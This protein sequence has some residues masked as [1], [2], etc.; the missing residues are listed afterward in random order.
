MNRIYLD[1]AASTPLAPEVWEAML[2]F[3]QDHYGNPSSTHAHG[4]QLRN[5]IEE[6]RRNIARHLG[7][8]PSEIIFTSGGTEADNMAIQGIV[9]AYQVKTII[10]SPIEHHAVTHCIE[11]LEAEGRIEAIWLTPLPD[12]NI[13]LDELAAVLKAH[14]SSL[15]SIMHANNE[16]GTITDLEAIGK[17][18]KEAGAFFHSDTVQTM[19]NVRYHLA[20]LP[21]DMIAASAHKFNGPKGVGFLYV[22]KGISMPSLI[23]GGSQERGHRA[24]T[25]NVAAIVGMGRALS[26]CY[27]RFD[28]KHDHLEHLRSYMREQLM[29][30]IPGVSF[31]GAADDSYAMPTV[32]NVT[33][34]DSVEEGMMLFQLDLEGVSVSG[35]SACQS[36]AQT[37]SHVLQGI[38]KSAAE[39]GRSVRFS[40]GWQNTKEEIDVVVGKLHTM[41]GK[42]VLSH[43]NKMS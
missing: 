9:E 17:L 10:S 37:G 7:A 29:E 15:V 19:T 40:F 33:F 2:P 27:D 34:P 8:Q 1:H 18:C 23:T 16:L 14:P 28:E 24:G 39:I 30:K 36:G 5:A 41:A 20:S 35:G 11:K 21:V 12:G 31:N 4:R 26:M 22:K 42:A 43:D 38:G 13:S 32:L 6:A 3:L 25:E